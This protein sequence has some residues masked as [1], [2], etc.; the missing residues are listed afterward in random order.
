MYVTQGLK[1]AANTN[2]NAIATIYLDRT[3]TWKDLRNRVAKMASSLQALGLKKNDKVAI[4][5]LNNDR[6][7]E[8]FFS[9]PWAGQVVVP[10]NTRL[11]LP[12]MEYIIEHSDAQVLCVDDQFKDA[13]I[14]LQK[15]IPMLQHLVWIGE[16]LCPEGFHDMEDLIR[17]HDP[18]PD[19]EHGGGDVYGLFYTGGTTGKAKGVMLT[20]DNIVSNAMV[21]IPPVDYNR[22]TRYLHAAPMF[23]AADC[24]STFAVTIMGGSHTFMPKFHPVHLLEQIEEQK[25]TATMLVPTMLNMV[26]N[27]PH[28]SQYK[29]SNL[30]ELIYGASPMPVPLIEKLIK[31]FPRQRF[32]QCLGMTEMAP[33]ITCLFPDRHV[34]EGEYA[35]KL[36]SV[37]QE[38]LTS[39]VRIV[40]SEGKDQPVGEVGELWVRGPMMMKGY[41]KNPEETE[42][43]LEG[44][45][46]HTGDCG[47]FDEDNFIFLVDRKKDMIISGGENVF[48][49]EVENVLFQHPDIQEC[50]VIGVPD[51]E[52]GERVHAVVVPKAKKE[53]SA[54]ELIDYC[55]GKIAGYKVPR[56][57]TFRDTALPLS[58]AG[59]VLKTELR[60]EYQETSVVGV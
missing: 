31:L 18:I 38:T 60:K 27:V 40:N 21:V 2:G 55:R 11:A 29:L 47:Y 41:W 8:L 30:K 37:G 45:W 57:V 49:L 43:T 50:A 42:R 20:H 5:S 56:S 36:G 26:A 54:D 35:G 59:K 28:L 9:V 33:V 15:H 24:G 13:A 3:K 22:H 34:L 46:L 1:R 16:G 6:Y 39:E 23:H 17:K 19:E 58:G 53:L 48:S 12:E 7:L 25:V 14:A 32:T 52:W 10:M 44:G 51:E 4:L